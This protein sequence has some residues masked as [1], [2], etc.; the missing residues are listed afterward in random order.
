MKENNDDLDENNNEEKKIEEEDLL[1]INEM[2]ENV[3]KKKQEGN[4][5]Y[6]LKKYEEAEK[7]YFEALNI[8]T[9]FKTKKK[10]TMNNEENKQIGKEIILTMKNLYSNIAL[11]QGK[12][13]K[14][15]EAISTS[16]YIISNLDGYHDK[17]YLRMILWKI[18]LL[19][20]NN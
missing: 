15:R 13:L 6:S 3:N 5:I 2:L 17:S 14:R 10:F 9:N 4:K 20:M 18:E 8:L 7:T 1:K 19:Y 11:C 12:Q 16:S